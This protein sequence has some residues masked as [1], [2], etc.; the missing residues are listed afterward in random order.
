[1]NF[2]ATDHWTFTTVSTKQ[3]NF[4]IRLTRR[5][6]L[7]TETVPDTAEAVQQ[8]VDFL[9]EVAAAAAVPDIV[10]FVQTSEILASHSGCQ[11]GHTTVLLVSQ[12]KES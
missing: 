7:P 10:S 9:S 3:L 11:L 12:G 4:H 1:M 2:I 6:D 8:S 5:N